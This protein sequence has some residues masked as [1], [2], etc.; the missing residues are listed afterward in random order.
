MGRRKEGELSRKRLGKAPEEKRDMPTEKNGKKKECEEKESGCLPL[1][2]AALA[3]PQ[4]RSIFAFC[5]CAFV[6]VESGAAEAGAAGGAGGGIGTGA[7]GGGCGTRSIGRSSCGVAIAVFE[8]T[9]WVVAF[10]SPR[11]PSDDA[12]LEV[13]RLWVSTPPAVADGAT[14]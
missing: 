8:P 11:P 1:Y 5:R 10:L 6:P 13:V 14:S 12:S 7:S 3:P 2:T 4:K 9:S